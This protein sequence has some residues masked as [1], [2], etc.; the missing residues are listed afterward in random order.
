MP[1]SYYPTTPSVIVLLSWTR[2]TAPDLDPNIFQQ[3]KM[4]KMDKKEESEEGIPL[5]AEK[6][7]KVDTVGSWK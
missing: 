4:E 3:E 7:E 2:F 5:V 6:K 1:T